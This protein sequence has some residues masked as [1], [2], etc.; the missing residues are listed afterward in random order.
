MKFLSPDSKFMTAMS[1]LGDLVV[2]NF[3]FLLTCL[4]VF[5]VGAALTALYTVCFQMASGREGGLLR[6][7]FRAFRANFG[8]ATGL[9]LLLVAVGACVGFDSVLFYRMSGPA[10]YL[11]FPPVVLLVVLV[12]AGGYVF[13]LLSQFRNTGRQTLK[14]AIFLSL[15]YLPRSMVVAL[16]NVF[17]FAVL[18]FDLVLFLETAFLWVFLYFS[19]IAYLNA[20]LL[21]K[22]F[23]PYFTKEESP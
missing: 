1:R 21:K 18:L 9:W 15:G 4:P 20:L 22:I 8:Q 12:L 7:Y 11:Y 6:G 3:V 16:L 19:A 5:T 14:N 13:P 17:P 2:L 10:H 23:E